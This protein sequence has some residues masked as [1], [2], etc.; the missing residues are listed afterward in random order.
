MVCF[1]VVTLLPSDETRLLAWDPW[2]FYVVVARIMSC[3]CASASP[4]FCNFCI[5]PNFF[6]STHFRKISLKWLVFRALYIFCSQ[7]TK[8]FSIFASDRVKSIVCGNT[9]YLK[10]FLGGKIGQSTGSTA[11]CILNVYQMQVL[12]IRLSTRRKKQLQM[13]ASFKTKH[14]YNR[15]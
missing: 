2:V 13:P 1:I 6:S 7:L 10:N 14:L 8:L 12:F 11:I 3:V 15:F 9:V 5:L 4:V